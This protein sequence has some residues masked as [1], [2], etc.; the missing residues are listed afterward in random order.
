M[1]AKR[2][3]ANQKAITEVFRSAGWVV[4]VTSSLGFGYPDLHVSRNGQAW[5]VEIKDGR[6]PL[7]QQKLTVD[8]LK[9]HATWQGPLIIIRSV[10][11]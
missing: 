6:K 8:E 4:F 5:L 3:D 7:S 1:R 2:T 10:C 9:F 11:I